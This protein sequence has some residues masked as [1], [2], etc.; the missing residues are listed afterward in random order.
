MVEPQHDEQTFR[1][2]GAA[3][4]IGFAAHLLLT[5][6]VAL[7]AVYAQATAVYDVT[8]FMLAGLPVWAVLWMLFKQHRL[9]RLESLEAEQLAASDAQAA[10]IFDEAGE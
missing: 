2:G 3:A 6:G 10:Q 9:E 4:F 7:M 1:R 5:V 8:W